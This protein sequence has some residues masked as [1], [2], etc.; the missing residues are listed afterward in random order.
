MCKNV[1]KNPYVGPLWALQVTGSIFH[2][3]KASITSLHTQTPLEIKS[4]IGFYEICGMRA[5]YQIKKN[6][7][8]GDKPT[9]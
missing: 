9:L 7:H 3:K 5:T 6:Y 4:V 2:K 1:E 8:E